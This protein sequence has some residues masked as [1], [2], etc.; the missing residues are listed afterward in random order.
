MAGFSRMFLPVPTLL[1]V[2][3]AVAPVPLLIWSLGYDPT[4]SGAN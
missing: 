1:T 2:A 4:F 3:L